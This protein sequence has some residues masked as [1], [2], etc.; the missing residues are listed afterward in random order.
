MMLIFSRCASILFFVLLFLKAP[1]LCATLKVAAILA[2]PDDESNVAATL[3]KLTHELKADVDIILI[4]NGES[5]YKYST[6]AEQIYHLALTDE[7]SAR[8]YLPFIRKQEALNGGKILGIR[9]YYFLEEEDPGFTLDPLQVLTGKWNIALI[10]E[11][12]KEIIKKNK[13]DFIFVMLPVESTHGHHKAATILALDVV[14]SLG[15]DKPL[16]LGALPSKQ[17]QSPQEYLPL[18]GF[19][20]TTALAKPIARVD[21]TQ[22]FG[23][24]QRLDYQIIV[25]WFIAEHKSQGALQKAMNQWD[26]ENFYFFEIN[27]PAKKKNV[28]QLFNELNKQ[29]KES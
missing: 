4:T 21:R 20:I 22:K 12:L 15:D 26:D 19:P 6:L 16:I 8:K 18:K 3:Y 10:K 11:K 24:D 13:Y 29:E 7:K 25:N 5:G 28:E 2:H 27:D 23:Y 9:N 1:V 14:S 17:S